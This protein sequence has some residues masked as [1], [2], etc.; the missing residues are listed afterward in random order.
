MYLIF[1]DEILMAQRNFFGGNK[2]HCHVLSFSTRRDYMEFVVTSGDSHFKSIY[3][4]APW[5]LSE[6]LKWP[7]FPAALWAENRVS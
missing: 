3:T 2:F 5:L 1:Q 4:Y 6:I 7:G